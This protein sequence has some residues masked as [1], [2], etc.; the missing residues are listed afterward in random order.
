MIFGG[1]EGSLNSS[2]VPS[3]KV[4]EIFLLEQSSERIWSN[5]VNN[6]AFFSI[7]QQ[8][9]FPVLVV[10]FPVIGVVAAISLGRKAVGVGRGFGRDARIDNF[11]VG[12]VGILP[13]GKL[14]ELLLGESCKL[15]DS[16]FEGDIGE[17][18]VVLDLEVVLV[19]DIFPVLAGGIREA[20]F[21]FVFVVPV[22]EAFGAGRPLASR[23]VGL[24]GIVGVGI[25]VVGIS[26]VG[27]VAVSVAFAV[28]V[29]VVALVEGEGEDEADYYNF[30][31]HNF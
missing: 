29:N 17:G 11:G 12:L 22:F 10:A 18:I 7:G 9:C 28:V 4:E 30:I 8:P 20:I 6:I 26:I 31:D 21:V 24:G 3:Q 2:P 14:F 1:A 25:A 5:L 27:R 19:E 13:Q 23:I 16:H 15:V